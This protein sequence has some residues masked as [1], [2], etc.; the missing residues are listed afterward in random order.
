MWGIAIQIEDSFDGT[1]SKHENAQRIKQIAENILNKILAKS[2]A[3]NDDLESDAN[4]IQILNKLK[5][6]AIESKWLA[7]GEESAGIFI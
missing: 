7:M 6:N 5:A 1:A 4:H 3:T 2:D